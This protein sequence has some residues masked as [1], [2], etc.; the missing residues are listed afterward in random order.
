MNEKGFYISATLYSLLDDISYNVT[1]FNNESPWHS[2][3]MGLRRVSLLSYI[4]TYQYMT[5]VIMDYDLL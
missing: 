2:L 3:V 5:L 4:P 1:S